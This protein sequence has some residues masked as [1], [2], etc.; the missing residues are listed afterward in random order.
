MASNP[1]YDPELFVAG[2]Q[3]RRLEDDQ[4]PGRHFSRA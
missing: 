1:T 2:H 4:R 3:Q